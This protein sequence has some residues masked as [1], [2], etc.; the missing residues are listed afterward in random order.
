MTGPRS[1][2]VPRSRPL[3]MDDM[4]SDTTATWTR[5]DGDDRRLT[6]RPGLSGSGPERPGLGDHGGRVGWWV[7][8]AD[9]CAPGA[10]GV[11]AGRPG[12][13]R[14]VISRT[15]AAAGAG[16][17]AH[18]GRRTH[19]DLRPD[20][21]GQDAH[22]LPRVDRPADHHAAARGALA[23]H[24]CALH[25]AAAGAGVRH[26]EEPAGAAEGHRTRRRAPRRERS[27]PPRSGCAPA[28]R[29]PTTARS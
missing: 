26:R 5:H 7:A 20:G 22:G 11:L 29:P 21:V 19:A 6:S 8:W 10:R 1:P 14:G 18:R 27:S 9:R 16:L 23:P 17:A 2:S 4:S 15:D 28:T 12:V 24:A 13:V 3:D 25:L